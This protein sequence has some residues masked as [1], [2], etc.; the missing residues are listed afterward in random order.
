MIFAFMSYFVEFG[1]WPNIS[2]LGNPGEER[3]EKLYQ[4]GWPRAHRELTESELT[5][6]EPAW[7]QLKPS[8]YM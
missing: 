7:D 6:R 5:T 8:T 3:N 1:P 4:P 2:L